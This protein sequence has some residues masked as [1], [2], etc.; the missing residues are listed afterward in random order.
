MPNDDESPDQNQCSPEQN[1]SSAEQNMSSAPADS[2]SAQPNY[3]P[4][5]GG[6]SSSQTDTPIGPPPPPESPNQSTPEQNYTPGDPGGQTSSQPAPDSS[7]SN[8]CTPDGDSSGGDTPLAA[9]GVA[10]AG[11][12]LAS[13]PQPSPEYNPFSGEPA[14]DNAVPEEDAWSGEAANDNAVADDSAADLEGGEAVEAGEVGAEGA[15]AAEAA[16]EAAEA[17]E[18]VEAVE[19]AELLGAVLAPEVVIPLLLIALIVAEDDAPV[20]ANNASEE[21]PDEDVDNTVGGQCEATAFKPV[22]A[23]QEFSDQT[24]TDT[25]REEITARQ[26]AIKDRLEDIGSVQVPK[27]PYKTQLANATD[28]KTKNK[29]LKRQQQLC[30]VLRRQLEA[31]EDLK[32][33]RDEMQERCFN[34]PKV[35]DDEKQRD[36][37]H[38]EQIDALNKAIE[39][40][41]KAI[42]DNC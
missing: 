36:K 19:G 2:S 33:V 14:N 16:T 38:K 29:I 5:D 21:Q 40:V 34:S 20:A 6:Q 17:A 30:D 32:K 3:T 25:E 9:G 15:E 42:Q 1:S 35:T 39:R 31:L 13:Q 11:A 18:A 7:Q 28:D 41:K 22:I 37:G 10:L 8:V 23:G 4:A 24:C 27:T 26:Q 12:P